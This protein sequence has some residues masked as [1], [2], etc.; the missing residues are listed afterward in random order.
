MLVIPK[1]R[2]SLI[3]MNMNIDVDVT[4][5]LYNFYD[6]TALSKDILDFTNDIKKQKSELNIYYLNYISTL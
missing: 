1:R 6:Y 5:S 2:E 4:K 3:K